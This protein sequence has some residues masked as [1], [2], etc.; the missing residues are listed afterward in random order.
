MQLHGQKPWAGIPD[1]RNR[2]GDASCMTR[3]DTVVLAIV[4]HYRR[5]PQPGA[6]ADSEHHAESG[7]RKGLRK[8]YGA[9]HPQQ[10]ETRHEQS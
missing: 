4:W 6:V 9:G 8:P 7:V 1:E 10:P 5:I 2:P 3:R